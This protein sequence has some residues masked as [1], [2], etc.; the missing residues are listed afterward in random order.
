[1]AGSDQCW[2]FDYIPAFYSAEN[3]Y[4]MAVNLLGLSAVA[5]I[6]H[7]SNNAI[8]AGFIVLGA[9]GVVDSAAVTIEELRAYWGA[10]LIALAIAAPWIPRAR[11]SWRPMRQWHFGAPPPLP[12][13]EAGS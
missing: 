7:A 1:V 3:P 2:L 5:I 10:P 8:A 9:H 13:S 6:A 11:R 4:P 12:R